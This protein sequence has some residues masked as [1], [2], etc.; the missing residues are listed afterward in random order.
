[1]SRL[2][3]IS[4]SADAADTLSSS[5]SVI[6]HPS[7]ITRFR[8]DKLLISVSID[9]DQGCGKSAQDCGWAYK[10]PAR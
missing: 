2:G 8:S 10:K 3:I 4:V 9:F 5:M 7:P 6:A 1:M